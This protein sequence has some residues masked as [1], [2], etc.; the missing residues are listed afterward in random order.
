MTAVAVWGP[1]TPAARRFLDVVSGAMGVR[2]VDATTAADAVVVSGPA[3]PLPAGGR[4]ISFAGPS[5]TAGR[6]VVSFTD[7]VDPRLRRV[8]ADSPVVATETVAGSV[9]FATVR[10]RPVW[11]ADGEGRHQRVGAPLPELDEG[12][13]VLDGIAD[14]PLA[15]VALLHFLRSV[16]PAD[17]VAP[18]P[19]A[20]FLIDDPNL[21][22]RS[23][24]FIDFA[25]LADDAVRHD[26]HVAVAMVPVDSWPVNDHA[27]RVFAGAGDRMSLLIH[28][29]DHVRR[30]LARPASA[31]EA[32]TVVAQAIRR[33]ERFERRSRL[34]VERVMV[35]PHGLCSEATM[36]ALLR[37]GFD[38]LCYSG[39]AP[40]RDDPARG[41]SITDLAVGG[42]PVI[43]RV[44]LSTSRFDVAMRLYLDQPIVLYGHQSDLADLDLLR[45]WAAFLGA[46]APVRWM[47]PG[48]LA[49]TNVVA[50]RGAGVLSVVGHARRFEVVV[51]ADVSSLVVERPPGGTLVR[52]ARVTGPVSAVT[53][54]LGVAFAVEPGTHVIDIEFDDPVD[55]WVVV[56]PPRRPWALARRSLVEARDRAAPLLSRGRR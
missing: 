21:R 51:P 28:G 11:A 22:W 20:S 34:D 2:L 25:T 31:A 54:E 38:A 42:L 7:A 45:E 17:A 13:R 10:G 35:A 39:Y 1:T 41:W 24:G 8:D 46:R 43:R 30:E 56:P 52:S 29:N 4:A 23:Y 12:Q 44:P 48:R 9:A 5:G 26:Y 37:L 27:R 33:I 36:Q 50:R 55:P 18:P 15:A 47:S 49:A 16:V 19:R 53:T 32:A 14:S 6:A 40:P 3:P